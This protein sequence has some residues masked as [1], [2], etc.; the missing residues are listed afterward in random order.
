MR[1]TLSKSFKVICFTA[2]PLEI[3]GQSLHPGACGFA[4]AGRGQ[5]LVTNIGAHDLFQV[6]GT[7]DADTK[8]PTPL[9][10]LPASAKGAYRLR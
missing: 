3:G 5:F 6:A 10:V 4:F 2:V 9:Q 7:K 8:R 1:P